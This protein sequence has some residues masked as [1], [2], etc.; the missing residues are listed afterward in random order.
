MDKKGAIELSMTTIIVIVLGITLLVLGLAWVNNLIGGASDL[1][2][3]ALKAGKTQINEM[4]GSANQPLNLFTTK[5]ELSQ[6]DY[7]QVSIIVLNDQG[8]E[9]QYTLETSMTAKKENDIDCYIADNGDVKDD[10][11]LGSGEKEDEVI[12]IEDTGNTALGIYSCNLE[13]KRNG[14]KISDASIT[15][16]VV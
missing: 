5:A 3:Q 1:T 2:D 10:F 11:S 9:G 6:G 4:L 7:T 12:L 14:E 16:E 8:D 13:L 15:I